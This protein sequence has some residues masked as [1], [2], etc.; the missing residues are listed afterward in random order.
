MTKTEQLRVTTWRSKILQHAAAISNVER[1]CRRFGISRKTFY[2][3]RRRFVEHGDAGL[4]D[5]SPTPR[6]VPRATADEVVSKI[7]YLRQ[8]YHFG[9]A[10]IA[11]YLQ[12][13][14]QVTIAK[15]DAK[16]SGRRGRSRWR[17]VERN[18]LAERV[19]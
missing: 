9:A 5:R 4:C 13:F 11:A 12:R 1:T 18:E 17:L 14:H 6:R 10:R 8:H 2:K 15:K 7:L 3:W 19:R 16:A